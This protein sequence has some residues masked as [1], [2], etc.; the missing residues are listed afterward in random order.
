MDPAI[1]HAIPHSK[2]SVFMRMQGRDVHRI[3]VWAEW[4]LCGLA[5]LPRI[6]S[7]NLEAARTVFNSRWPAGR[8]VAT[9][10][11][12][13]AAGLNERIIGGAVRAGILHRLRR[14][15]YAP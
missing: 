13:V 14:G 12:L 7:M 4:A 5:N 8:A 3:G 2:E 10:N 15:V 6:S 9:T 11:Q 1:H